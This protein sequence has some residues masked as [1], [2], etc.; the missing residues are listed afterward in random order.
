M[1]V[2]PM[3]RLR[4]HHGNESGAGPPRHGLHSNAMALI[5]SDCD[6]ICFLIIKRPDSCAL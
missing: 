1:T 3:A 5:A 6:A 4:P 2:L